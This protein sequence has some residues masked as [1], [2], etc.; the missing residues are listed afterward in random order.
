LNSGLWIAR[1]NYLFTLVR[2][3][4]NGCGGDSP[5]FLVKSYDEIVE[6]CPGEEIE[7]AIACYESVAR[8]IESNYL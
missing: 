6:L 7:K 5:E 2:R 8:L 3:V 4:S 1:K